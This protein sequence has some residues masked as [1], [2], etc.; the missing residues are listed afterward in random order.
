MK[1]RTQDYYRMMRERANRRK[2]AIIKDVWGL[3]IEEYRKGNNLSKTHLNCGCEMC[4]DSTKMIGWKH[5][6]KIN[7]MKGDCENAVPIKH[8]GK[9]TS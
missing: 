3:N 2:G 9:Y 7:M 6:D 5:S 8:K 1:N 4:N